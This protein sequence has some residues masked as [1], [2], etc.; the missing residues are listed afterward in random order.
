MNVKQVVLRQYQKIV[1]EAA[2]KL[3]SIQIPAEGWV[4]TV[5]KALGMSV[6]QLSRLMRISHTAIFRVEKKERS[7]SV[8]VKTLQMIAEAMGCRF[9]YAIIPETT[10]SKIIANRALKKAKFLV[11][12]AGNQMVLESQGLSL[13]QMQ[14]EIERL[15]QELQLKMPSDLWEDR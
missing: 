1:D 3:R 8:T 9:V 5:R 10:T 12:Q 6:P 14:Q 15:C 2:G 11:E 13:K 4:C 7:G